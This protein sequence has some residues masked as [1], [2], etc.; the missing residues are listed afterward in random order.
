MTLGPGYPESVYIE[1]LKHE[2]QAQNIPYQIAISFP[3]RYKDAAVGQVIADFI[4]DGKFI[5]EVMCEF[6]DVSSADRAALRAQ[7]K[8]SDLTL[9]LITNF[10]GRRLTDGLVR[11]LN[12]DKIRAE[13][14]EDFGHDDQDHGHDGGAVDFDDR[15]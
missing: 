14:G 15:A 6:R 1:A 7:L 8:A 13:R 2:F 3:V 4:I 10:A 5:L 12:V 11:V 9:G